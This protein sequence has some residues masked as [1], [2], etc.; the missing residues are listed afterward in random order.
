M[1]NEICKIDMFYDFIDFRNTMIKS[2]YRI[3]IKDNEN[4]TVVLNNEQMFSYEKKF[5]NDQKKIIDHFSKFQS[6]KINAT[7]FS[8]INF[9]A[10]IFSAID[11]DAIIF[12]AN[13]FNAIAFDVFDRTKSEEILQLSLIKRFRNR[14]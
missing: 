4:T 5:S 12:R 2:Y 7:A 10:I 13:A 8:A 9:D 3:D 11:F 14:F 1:K 6:T